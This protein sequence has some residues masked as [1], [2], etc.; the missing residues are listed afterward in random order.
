MDNILPGRINYLR[1][2]ITDRCNLRCFYCTSWGDWQKL[3]APEIL[4][5]EEM[6]RLAGVAAGV[7]IKKLRVTGGEPLVR[8]GVLS[9]IRHLHQVPG[10]EEV[11]LTTN[12]VR[13]AELAPDLL[14]TGLRHLN[15]SLDT[16]RPDRYR[17]LT[18]F[19]HFGD[20]MAGLERAAALGFNPVKINC[21]V[22][23]DLND[24]ELLDFAR[25]TRDHPFQVRFIEFMPTVAEARWRR[26]FLPMTEIRRRLA[27]LGPLEAVTSPATAGPARTFRLPGFRG[28]LGFISSVSDHHCP[29]CNRLRLTAAGWLRPCLF[30]APELD[31]KGPLRQ[32]ASDAAL[33]R[34]FQEAIRLKGC[35]APAPTLASPW[36]PRS[37][38]SIGG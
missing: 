28:E 2:S 25:L 22:L 15:L 38:V 14:A 24:D 4:R 10:I 34:L 16:L 18:G 26:H 17:E 3:P 19:D 31:I 33:A 29:T 30:A 37:M 1:V 32:G 11:C 20:V 35:V 6:L 13:L 8:R 21:V 23:R 27:E 12:G 5:Y 36:L 9:F 7:G